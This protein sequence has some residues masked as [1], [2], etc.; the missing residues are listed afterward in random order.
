[1]PE[2][3][4]LTAQIS[5]YLTQA[6][7]D[8]D[9]MLRGDKSLGAYREKFAMPVILGEQTETFTTIN[10]YLYSKSIEHK[11]LLDFLTNQIEPAP[12]NPPKAEWPELD[13]S[14]SDVPE[15]D[16]PEPDLPEPQALAKKTSPRFC[17]SPSNISFYSIA[18]SERASVTPTTNFRYLQTVSR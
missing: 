11:C 4:L 10:S 9:I 18:Q 15:Y 7:A 5:A 14:E 1:M 13:L 6:D 3:L 2:Q 12:S 8:L 16:L 17:L